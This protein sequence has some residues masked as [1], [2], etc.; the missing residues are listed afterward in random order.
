MTSRTRRPAALGVVSLLLVLGACDGDGLP[1]REPDGSTPA[2]DA[3]VA[4]DAPAATDPP[5]A[6]DP[7]LVTDPPVATDAPA[8]TEAPPATG[9]PEEGD[10]DS[11]PWLLIVLVVAALGAAVVA[12]VAATRRRPAPAPVADPR[13]QILAT[14]RWVHDQLSL[15]I[16]ALP[17]ADAV[18]RWNAE[19]FR[20]DQLVID[21]RAAAPA[22]RVPPAW[23]ALAASVAELASSL[24]SAVRIRA[25]AEADPSLVREAVGIADGHRAELQRRLLIVEQGG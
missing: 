9:T 14:A 4:T 22:Q 16:L 7:P 21:L 24:D 3:P 23:E 13:R 10:D 15:E 1:G 6:T 25:S 18:A 17:A 5:V 12:F 2:T 11:P 8:V 19:R 20:L